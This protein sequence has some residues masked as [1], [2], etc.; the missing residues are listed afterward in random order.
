MIANLI[1]INGITSDLKIQIFNATLFNGKPTRINFPTAFNT[2]CIGVISQC[3]NGLPG[4][5]AIDCAEFDTKGFTATLEKE[6]SQMNI[7]M[8]IGY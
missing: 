6:G 8:A 3:Y 4:A 2:K 1:E 5:L 7:F